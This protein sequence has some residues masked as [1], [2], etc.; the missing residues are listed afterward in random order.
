MSTFIII[1]NGHIVVL[2]WDIIGVDEDRSRGFLLYY[3]KT[4]NLIISL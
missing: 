4:G 2:Y 3:S 1:W